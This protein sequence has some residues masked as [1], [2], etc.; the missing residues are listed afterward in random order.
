MEVAFP[1]RSIYLRNADEEEALPLAETL[2]VEKDRPG[3]FSI[4]QA[5]N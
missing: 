1:S 4:P 2:I 5:G 3:P